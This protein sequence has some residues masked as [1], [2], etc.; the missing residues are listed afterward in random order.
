MNCVK[1]WILFEP[2]SEVSFIHFS[3]LWPQNALR[4]EYSL[5]FLGCFWAKPKATTRSI[6][7]NYKLC[8]NDMSHLGNSG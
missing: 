5:G 8:I 2:T 6:L 4:I 1:K 7:D 3:Y